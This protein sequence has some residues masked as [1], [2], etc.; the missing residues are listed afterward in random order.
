MRRD[1]ENK[2][3]ESGRSVVVRGREV[4]R[5]KNSRRAGLRPVA[6]LREKVEE[7]SASSRSIPQERGEEE[8]EL[9]EPVPTTENPMEIR[10]R[11]QGQIQAARRKRRM[12]QAPPVRQQ[13]PGPENQPPQQREQ[14]GGPQPQQGATSGVRFS[15]LRDLHPW[16]LDSLVG[17]TGTRL[18]LQASRLE[19]THPEGEVNPFRM[20]GVSEKDLRLAAESSPSLLRFMRQKDRQAQQVRQLSQQQRQTTQVNSPFASQDSSVSFTSSGSSWYP[21]QE[22]PQWGDQQSYYQPAQ[23]QQQPQPMYDF[24][25]P[26]GAPFQAPQQHQQQPMYQQPAYYP[27]QQAPSQYSYMGPESNPGMMFSSF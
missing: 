19:A 4:V 26:Q 16:Q 15:S 2:N 5:R 20:M 8:A 11:L 13:Q 22:Q 9:D 3:K 10:R 27:S 12:G 6:R 14:R 1:R 24:S 18:H 23:H 7:E 21:H 17:E 25:P